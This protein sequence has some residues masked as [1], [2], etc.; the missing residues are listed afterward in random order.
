MSRPGSAPPRNLTLTEELEK[1]EQSITLTLQGWTQNTSAGLRK[2]TD[3]PQRS[4]TTSARP[5]ASSQAAF[6]PL[7]NSMASTRVPY[8]TPQRLVLPETAP[9]PPHPPPANHCL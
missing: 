1:L 7:S 9:P 5:I 6:F 2:T 8:G 4:T 3:G